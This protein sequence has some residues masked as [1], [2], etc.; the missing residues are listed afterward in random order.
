MIHEVDGDILLT[1]AEAIAHGVAPND[2]FDQGL[3]LALRE[4]WPSMA[5]DFR[6]WCHTQSPEPGTAWIWRGP[7]GACVINLL[8]QGAAPRH[9][10]GH[11]GPAA[12][13]HVN[14]ALRAL[15]KLIER[16]GLGSV[17]LPRLATG[18][19][20]L[21]WAEVRPLIERHLGDLGCTIQLY[22]TY[23]PHEQ[24]DERLL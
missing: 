14:H 12:L 4:R 24:A 3:A 22:V 8:T 2:H 21:D 13:P 18:V 6:H 23:H 9:A 1:S 15:R 5:R 20:E 11:P 10:D 19:G 7:E 17:A 16:E